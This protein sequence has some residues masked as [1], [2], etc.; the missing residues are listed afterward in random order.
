M[1]ADYGPGLAEVLTYV[2]GW[3]QRKKLTTYAPF[4]SAIYNT[5][6]AIVRI[7]E[8]T[9]YTVFSDTPADQGKALLKEHYPAARYP[10]LVADMQQVLRVGLHI[11]CLE[12]PLELLTKFK[13]LVETYGSGRQIMD[14]TTARVSLLYHDFFVII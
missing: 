4:F 12:G 7:L 1:N 13:S 8:S 11:P 14:R 6:G 5:V 9:S 2:Q 3:L 10:V